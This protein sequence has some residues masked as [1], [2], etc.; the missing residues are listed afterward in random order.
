MAGTLYHISVCLN[1]QIRTFEVGARETLLHMI[2]EQAGLTGTKCGCNL[3]ECG[4]CT[5]ILD[6]KAVNSCCVLA[7]QADGS[8]V[9]TI[10]GLGTQEHPHPLQRAFA[11]VGAIQC[12]F[13]TPGMILSAKALLDRI[14]S[15]SHEE[16][17]DALSGNLCRCTGYEKIIQAVELAAKIING[18]VMG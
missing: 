1:H 7:Q 6:K 10:E 4:A 15:P 2:R 5:V 17:R 13:C 14:P 18:D 3:G 16:I 9:V 8:E 12:G 11:D